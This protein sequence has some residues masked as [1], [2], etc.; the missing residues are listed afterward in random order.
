MVD[1]E[2]KTKKE[3]EFGC[4]CL[5]DHSQQKCVVCKKAPIR[6]SKKIHG[7]W[8][9]VCSDECTMTAYF[10]IDKKKAGT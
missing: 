5:V 3:D 7:R 10:L 9:H 6:A 8:I 2:T 4:G 1:A